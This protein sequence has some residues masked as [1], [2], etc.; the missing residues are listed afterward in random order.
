LA[1][2][3]ADGDLEYLGRIDQQVKIRGFRIEL[4]EIERVLAAVPGVR[5]AVVLAREDRPGERRLVAYLVPDPG[6]SVS[7][8]EARE[9]C[10]TRLADYMVPAAFVMLERLPLTDNGKL[11][12]RAL[13]DGTSA[14]AF[15]ASAA[16]ASAR[17]RSRSR[18][19]GLH[20]SG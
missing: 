15:A 1:R 11:D 7:A 3:L 14:A 6:V 13:P 5:D 10:R 2:W 19:S 9:A 16:S 12:R 8:G 4:G 17:T 20:F 18:A